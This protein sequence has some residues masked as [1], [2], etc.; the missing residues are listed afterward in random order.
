MVADEEEVVRALGQPAEVS[1]GDDVP[2]EDVPKYLGRE[3]RHVQ[4]GV[5]GALEFDYYPLVL[6]DLHIQHPYGI[7]VDLLAHCCL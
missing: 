4:Q 1:I 2:M 5:P 7:E 3:S 6:F